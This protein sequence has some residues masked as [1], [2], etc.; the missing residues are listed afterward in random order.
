MF[1]RQ[2]TSPVG[3]GAGGT[4]EN[5]Y[6]GSGAG[7][8]YSGPSFRTREANRAGGGGGIQL[9]CAGR[10]DPCVSGAGGGSSFAAPGLEVAAVTNTAISGPYISITCASLAG[11]SLTRTRCRRSDHLRRT[12]RGQ[13]APSRDPRPTHRRPRAALGASRSREP[14]LRR[15]I[16]LVPASASALA[17]LRPRCLSFTVRALTLLSVSTATSVR[18]AAVHVQLLRSQC[19]WASR[20]WPGPAWSR[21]SRDRP[22]G[23]CA[24]RPRARRG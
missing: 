21:A 13:Y 24:E 6:G 2:L 15:R 3:Y 12:P 1:C 7:A 16:S 4:N 11:P 17:A 19:L 23:P 5:Q 22:R 8:G 10:G 20:R 14:R 9:S 18:T